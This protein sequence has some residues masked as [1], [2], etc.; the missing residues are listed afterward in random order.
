MLV[1]LPAQ[2]GPRA[3][4]TS[5]LISLQT[6]ALGL[7]G[8]SFK[9]ELGIIQFSSNVRLALQQHFDALLKFLELKFVIIG[10]LLILTSI[11]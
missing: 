9:F 2:L 11:S 4:T 3:Q 10:L 7:S 8:E 1:L 5:L 6:T